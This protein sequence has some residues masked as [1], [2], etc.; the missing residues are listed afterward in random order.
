[1]PFHVCWQQTV[2]AVVWFSGSRNAVAGQRAQMDPKMSSTDSSSIK[3]SA[4]TSQESTGP[5]AVASE[6]AAE[7]LE[8][9]S[10]RATTQKAP[11]E[12]QGT[13]S[14]AATVRGDAKERIQTAGPCTK[15]ELE[16][17]RKEIDTQDQIISAL[18][19]DNE[20]LRTSAKQLQLHAKEV[21][22]K[23]ANLEAKHSLLLSA[24]DGSPAENSI[25]VRKLAAR[26]KEL[27][28]SLEEA[29]MRALSTKAEVR[30]LLAE[31]EKTAQLEAELRSTRLEKRQ[32]DLSHKREIEDLRSRIA[33]L[34]DVNEARQAAENANVSVA[35]IEHVEVQQDQ[36]QS[37][38][39]ERLRSRVAELE[40]ELAQR[41]T[42]NIKELIQTVQSKEQLRHTKQLE[43]KVQQ[44]SEALN[45]KDTCMERMVER[46]RTEA[47]A[48]RSAYEGKIKQLESQLRQSQHEQRRAQLTAPVA[49]SA[50]VAASKDRKE[51]L[52]DSSHEA[53]GTLEKQVRF[54]ADTFASGQKA[55]EERA[56]ALESELEG[57]QKLA[58]E[59]HS[60]LKRSNEMWEQKSNAFREDFLNQLRSVRQK[61]NEDI[62]RLQ[63]Y[64]KEEM[65]RVLEELD[66]VKK[67]NTSW[68]LPPISGGVCEADVTKKAFLESAVQRL[69]YLERHFLQRAKESAFEVAE[70]KRIALAEQ[71]LQKE[72]YEILLAQK[73][74]QINQFR[75]ELDDLIASIA[76][77]RHTSLC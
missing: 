63:R 13:P 52:P 5:Q 46:L 32:T 14:A 28:R 30:S 75:M 36:F 12:H 56:S 2:E 73:N 7:L 37:E 64:H 15:E 47:S 68:K 50:P 33:E 21:E 65:T 55:L 39:I 67:E 16:K 34:T 66:A 45:E 61:H 24:T 26:N 69:A 44:L 27:Q 53:A 35:S 38:E 19:K 42:D 1:M 6:K 10:I 17:V 72:K 41:N 74:Q 3:G 23:L 49:S 54:A 40:R 70:T 22:S 48:I 18:Q 43:S 4:N 25:E 58:E 71:Q 11:A 60:L 8:H 51:S 57:Y 62:D 9:M 76:C 31:V 77:L 29:E 20:A 59:S